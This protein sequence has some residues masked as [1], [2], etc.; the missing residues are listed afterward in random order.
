MNPGATISPPTSTI[1]PRAAIEA[2]DGSRCARRATATSPVAR[3][4]AA[5]VADRSAAQDQVGPHVGEIY[6][7]RR[8]STSA[9]GWG[10]LRP[11]GRARVSMV[12]SELRQGAARNGF[13]FGRAH[14]EAAQ[15]ERRDGRRVFLAGAAL[16]DGAHAREHRTLHEV[17][18][19]R[20]LR[21]VKRRRRRPARRSA[22]M[23]AAVRSCS[24]GALLHTRRSAAPQVGS[25]IAWRTKRRAPIAIRSAGSATPVELAEMASTRRSARS[26]RHRLHQLLA[27]AEVIVEGA[28]RDPGL[29]GDLVDRRRAGALAGKDA[30]GGVQEHA[31]GAQARAALARGGRC[32]R[33][34]RRAYRRTVG[35][36]ERFIKY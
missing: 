18:C 35:S 17:G 36:N 16:E 12:G 10:G 24:R 14:P 26:A 21:S 20:S 3:R 30:Q 2:P 27:R 33:P 31:A 23:G 4:R 25:R 11:C 7:T 5:A 28:V 6:R 13:G 19:R 34:R 8:S 1:A 32:G 29:G 22:S 9:D 15:H